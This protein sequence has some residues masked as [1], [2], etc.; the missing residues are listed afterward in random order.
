MTSEKRI[1]V[2]A[3]VI[4]AYAFV[5]YSAAL[6][7]LGR[8]TDLLRACSQYTVAGC[9]ANDSIIVSLLSLKIGIVMFFSMGTF[10]WGLASYL[11]LRWWRLHHIARLP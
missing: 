7:F 4:A 8:H 10:A 9:S 6:F 5:M 3:A 1:V 2:S 11:G